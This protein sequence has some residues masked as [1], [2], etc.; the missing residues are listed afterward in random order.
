LSNQFFVSPRDGANLMI[1]AYIAAV[2]GGWGSLGGAVVG[3]LF[4][5]LFQVVVA[6]YSSYLIATTLLYVCV[7]AVLVLRPSGLFGETIRKRV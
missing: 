2:L 6:A 3:A 7:L 5:A 1:A 4:I